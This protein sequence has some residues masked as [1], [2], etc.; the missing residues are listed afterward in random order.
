MKYI[1]PIRQ[2]CFTDIIG[3]RTL[4]TEGTIGEVH[5]D[6]IENIDG[7]VTADIV[8]ENGLDI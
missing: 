3:D 5:E 1:P 8:I 4:V 2:K 7:N 6:D